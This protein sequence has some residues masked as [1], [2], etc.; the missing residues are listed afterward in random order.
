LLR[1][2][3]WR[4]LLY[5]VEHLRLWHL[6]GCLN[7]G[8]FMNNVLPLQVGELGR[9]Y[10]LSELAGVS[11]TRVLSTVVVERVVDV[12]TLLLFLLLLAPFVPIPTAARI[13]AVVL[14]AAALAVAFLLVLAS[15]RRGPIPGLV[16]RIIARAPVA[17][18]PKLTQMTDSAIEGFG[19]LAEPKMAAGLAVLSA[20]AWGTMGLVYYAGFRAFD[21]TLGYEAGLLLVIATTF[22]FFFPS[23]PGSFGVYHAI[24]IGTLTSVFDVDKN[25]AVSFALVMHLVFYLPPIAVGTAFLWVE[26]RVWERLHF[27]E[28][29]GELRGGLEVAG[30]GE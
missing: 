20:L 22:G 15:R 24:A 30:V 11:T 23:S 12:L 9:V 5:S 8:Y 4:L 17:S 6:F 28:K 13:P 29:L 26:R 18:R 25:L 21:L 16:H 14:A 7:F 3:R 1:A 19:V 10:M 27:F 2:I